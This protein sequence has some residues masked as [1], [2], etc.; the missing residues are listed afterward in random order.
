LA[1]PADANSS[2]DIFGGWLLSQMDIARRHLRR[3]TGQG[4]VA[5]DSM[6]KPQVGVQNLS[7]NNTTSTD[8]HH[9]TRP[10]LAL[11]CR[12]SHRSDFVCLLRDFDRAG[13]ATGM[14]VR[15]PQQTADGMAPKRTASRSSQSEYAGRSAL[16]SFLR[17]QGIGKFDDQCG[18]G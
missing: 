7:H 4:R 8:Q 10:L 17:S 9:R 18:D 12:L 13:E 11:T 3:A 2:G 6:D 14:P 1:T 5:K 15:D 16:A